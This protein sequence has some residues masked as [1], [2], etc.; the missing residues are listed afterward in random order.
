LIKE[1]I[2]SGLTMPDYQ[3]QESGQF[4][5]YDYQN[6]RPFASFLPGISGTMGIPLWVFYVNRGQAIASFGVENKDKPILEFQT[7]NRAFQLTSYMGFRTFIRMRRGKKQIFYEPFSRGASL[8]KMV[9]GA[10]ELCL[11]EE[12]TA[13]GLTT[14]VVYYLLPEENLAGL[15]RLVT[16]TNR[17]DE[18]IGLEM[19][20]GLPAVIPFGVNNQILKDIGQTVEAWMEVYNL[21]QNVPFYHL[22]ASVADTTEVSSFE[23]GHYMLAF[24]EGPDGPR[25]LPAIVDPRLIFG[26]NTSLSKPDAF[27]QNGLREMLAQ[28]QITCG[29]TPCGFSAVQAELKPGES[30][31]LNSLFG[32]A[33]RLEN[34]QTKI[35]FLVSTSYLDNKRSEA[36]ELVNNLSEAIACRTSLPIF[37][38]YCRQTFLDNILRGGWPIA[39][40]R[41]N[42]KSIY[43]IYSRK[44]GDL[45]RDYNSFS[46]APE[47]YSQGNGSYRDINQNRREDVWFLPS[48]GDFNIRAFISLIQL[49]GYN[50]LILQGSRFEVLPEKLDELLAMTYDSERMRG[51]LSKPFTPGGLLKRI[52]D[53]SIPLT[54]GTQIFL[55][56]V[57]SASNQQA[58]ATFGEGYWI[59]HWTYNLDMIEGYLV[60]YPDRKNDLLFSRDDLPFYDSP[61]IV[62]PRSRKYVLEGDRPRQFNSI[63]E[64]HKKAALMASKGEGPSWARVG[65]G[66]GAVYRSSLFVKLINLAVLKF[67]TLDP[68]GMGIE[69]EAGRP[70]WYDAL[71][72]LP[73]LFGSSMPETYALKRLVR[74][75]GDVIK[76]EETGELRLH[77]EMMRLLRRVVKANEIYH[78]SDLEERD[79]LYWDTVSSAREAYRASIRQ[80]PDG[81]EKYLPQDELVEILGIFETKIDAGIQRALALNNGIPPTYFTFHV[82]EF[83]LLK[84]NKGRQLSDAQERPYIRIKKFTPRVLPLFL[85]GVVKAMNVSDLSSAKKIYDQVKEGPLYDQKLKMYKVNAS[86]LALPKDIGRARA[87]TPGW[88]ENE[89]IWLHMEYKYLLEILRAGLYEEFFT[90][91]RNGLIPFLDPKIYGRSTLENSSFIVSSAHPDVLLHGAGFVARLSGAT[92]EFISMW[93]ILMAGKKPFFVR[94]GQLCLTLKPILPAWMFTEE[95]TLA[96]NFLGSTT[97]NYHNQKRQDTFDPRC[98]A[99]S[100]ILY[101]KEGDSI[102]IGGD[103][104]PAPYAKMVRSGQIRKI[105]VYFD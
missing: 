77:I 58:D 97:V 40:G 4:V 104:V 98:V 61:M 35:G 55:E 25:I 93:R 96:F 19:L 82:D 7:A 65:H 5:I 10:N 66:S 102:K 79:F 43:H 84:D 49:D 22:R 2:E 63:A 57:I 89:S 13:I 50:P 45:E 21:D 78:S 71:N 74:F 38:A 18:P 83:V 27:I 44:H 94:A 48:V 53:D 95:N 32:H 75:L 39:F 20:D 51:L 24:H 85:E 42:R 54:V 17:S 29:R 15:V 69:M 28:K 81:T 34:I 8:Q 11:Q 64:D 86:L 101:P 36:N 73:G 76:D 31:R 103:I 68:W 80:G 52:A 60:V 105:D 90:D 30:I 92:A 62:N 12:S 47:F 33:S 1:A 3:L 14:D 16:V 87:F 59:D 91:F 26:Q 72:G 41:D 56:M 23:A 6:S 100:I 46:L 67:A 37:D 99:H 9:I 70:G 88:L